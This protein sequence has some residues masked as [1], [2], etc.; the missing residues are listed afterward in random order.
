MPWRWWFQPASLYSF[1]IIEASQFKI[2]T[3]KMSLAAQR[4]AKLRRKQQQT[5]RSGQVEEGRV[6]TDYQTTILNHNCGRYWLW[7]S[8]ASTS[9]ILF[10]S[11]HMSIMAGEWLTDAVIN[12][13]QNL[14]KEKYPLI[15][16]LQ[17]TTLGVKRRCAISSYT[18]NMCYNSFKCQ[19]GD[20]QLSTNS[21]RKWLWFIFYCFCYYYMHWI[22]PIWSTIQSTCFPMDCIN[23]WC[24]TLFP[25]TILPKKRK[26]SI[27][28]LTVA[29]HCQC[30]Q[31]EGGKMARC[32]QCHEW[33]HEEYVSLPKD[34]SL[35]EWSC[36]NCN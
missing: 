33:Y 7:K 3:K 13:A 23:K 32:D 22:W 19:G 34:I 10:V 14:L 8:A 25:Y 18:G 4:D 35:I 9:A 16:S 12:C 26:R 21:K 17:M 28:P 27:T 6:I 2:T 11:D 5:P 30:R 15:G 31:L 1:E 29:L 20:I 24:I 36:P